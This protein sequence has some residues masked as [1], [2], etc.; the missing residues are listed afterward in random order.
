MREGLQRVRRLLLGDD[1]RAL[2]FFLLPVA[3]STAVDLPLRARDM[4]SWQPHGLAIY[5]SSLLVGAGFW[6]FPLA[7]AAR[8]LARHGSDSTS[9][10]K[11]VGA[12]AGLVAFFTLWVLPV[13]AFG[14]A[15]QWLYFHVFR[16]YAGRDTLRLGALLRGSSRAWLFAWT[17]AGGL[18]FMLVFGAV[19]T[20]ALFRIVRRVAPRVGG[21]FPL[22]PALAFP[23]ALVCFWTDN[24]DS[25]FLQAS[26]PDMSFVHSVVHWVR[27][28][29]TGAGRVRQGVTLRMP[30]P[31]PPLTSAHARPP[32]VFFIVTESVRADALCSAPPPA[33]RQEFLDDAD[34]AADRIPLGKLTSQAPNTF[35]AC[36]VLWTGLAPN[37]DF[38]EA[39]QAPTLWEIAHAVGYRTAYVTSQNPRYEDFGVYLHRAGIDETIT[40]LD[41]HGMAHEH[42]GAPDELAIAEAVRFVRGVDANT[43]YF[44][45][46][47][48]SNTHHPYRVDP[49]LQPFTPHA[50]SVKAGGVDAYHNRYRNSVLMQARALA[51]MLRELRALPSWDR[52]V[53]V[54]VSD[55][56]EPF[57]EHGWVHHNHTLFEEELRVPGFIVAGSSA[58]DDRSRFALRTYANARTYAED[59]NATIV[60]LFGVGDARGTLPFA[61]DVKGRSLVRFRDPRV[62]PIAFAA[63]ATGVWEP[64]DPWFGAIRRDAAYIGPAGAPWACYDLAH[65]PEEQTPLPAQPTCAQLAASAKGEFPLDPDAPR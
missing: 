64:Y 6:V 15:G 60:D 39:H 10:P 25:R 9:R 52:T 37:V 38:T 57:D 31:L 28:A 16:S 41:L 49:A 22:L 42:L 32:N 46:L 47:Q 36:M 65:D 14:D 11:L 33:C 63:T 12:R 24:V 40:A 51:G 8:V 7:L 35:S 44:A 5:F 56:G 58:L 23:G 53:V 2:L 43:P 54:L 45:V 3:I 13:F 55:H 50:E 30:A 17:T 29:T 4:V 18:A 21:R 48:L 20:F 26:T 61:A 19:V 59:V 1:P 34:A 27:T 62:E